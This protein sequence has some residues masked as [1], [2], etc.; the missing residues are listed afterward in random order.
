MTE[1]QLRIEFAISERCCGLKLGMLAFA[2]L[3]C[4]AVVRRRT[5]S[6]HRQSLRGPTDLR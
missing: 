1:Q 5:A 3:V 4:A 2:L 6:P